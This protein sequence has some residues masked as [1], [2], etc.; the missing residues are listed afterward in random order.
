MLRAGSV[1]GLDYGLRA[2]GYGSQYGNL[3][4]GSTHQ[5]HGLDASLATGDQADDLPGDTPEDPASP[6]DPDLPD[7][8]PPDVP[9]AQVAFFG[10][11]D[12]YASGLYPL[13]EMTVPVFGPDSLDFPKPIALATDGTDDASFENAAYAVVDPKCAR[14]ISGRLSSKG[15]VH[16]ANR[17]ERNAR[18]RRPAWQLY[19]RQ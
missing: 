18:G 3:R 16:V 15:F 10:C 14:Q 12:L 7:E 8:P 19:V 11:D 9:Y 17:K 6:T 4:P 2:T 1:C 5:R 13:S